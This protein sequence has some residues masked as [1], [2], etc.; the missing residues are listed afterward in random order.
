MIIED[1]SK[2][3]ITVFDETRKF[4]KKRVRLILSFHDGKACI[5]FNEKEKMYEVLLPQN[6]P[7]EPEELIRDYNLNHEYHHIWR[8]ICLPIWLGVRD[9][10]PFKTDSRIDLETLQDNLLMNFISGLNRLN[11][12]DRKI[13]SEKVLKAT[14][15]FLS[16]VKSLELPQ[17]LA[18]LNAFEDY[19]IELH[20]KTMHENLRNSQTYTMEALKN[21]IEYVER[22]Q[23]IIR[24][25][26]GIPILIPIPLTPTKVELERVYQYFD[27]QAML[28]HKVHPDDYYKS[29]LS[30]GKSVLSKTHKK[31][32]ADR[33][34][35][36]LELERVKNVRKELKNYLTQ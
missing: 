6:T 23:A 28:I 2:D 16:Y 10:F 7:K 36:K 25:I 22:V 14:S 12:I 29:Y 27:F 34:R 24:D 33:Y 17:P 31:A 35:I 8:V 21:F 26:V 18:F 32:F 9:D 13:V 15:Y 3:E 1:I 11:E 30:Y 4:L 19:A 20:L 5:R